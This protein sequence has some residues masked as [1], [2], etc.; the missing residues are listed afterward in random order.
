MVQGVLKILYQKQLG[1]ASD[2]ESKEQ[3]LNIHFVIE[4]IKFY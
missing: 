4:L 3:N 1:V 2:T